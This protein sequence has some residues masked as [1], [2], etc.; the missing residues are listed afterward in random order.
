MFGTPPAA[1]SALRFVLAAN[2]DL[3]ILKKLDP[4]VFRWPSLTPRSA[5]HAPLRNHPLLS[6][7]RHGTLT[8]TELSKYPEDTRMY[9]GVGRMFLLQTRDATTAKLGTTAKE[10]EQSISC[11]RNSFINNGD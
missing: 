1:L 9:A 2:P 6:A 4:L 3:P 7:I 5:H 8:S 10:N 11:F